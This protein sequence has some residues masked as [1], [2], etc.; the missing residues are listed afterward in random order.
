MEQV[1]WYVAFAFTQELNVKDSSKKYRLPTEAEW[2]Y[3]CRAGTATPFWFDYDQLDVWHANMHTKKKQT[4][5]VGKYPSNFFGI[6]DQ[7]GQVW[8]WCQDWYAADYYQLFANQS[9]VDPTGPES[10][11][12]RCLR[13]GSWDDAVYCRSA[14]RLNDI[15]TSRNYF[16]GFRVLC[17]MW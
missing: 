11:A 9:A 3:A 17:E 13:G 7:H 12:S 10:G 1:S 15:P 2:E 5:T 8:E 6:H 16:I 4:S 14:S